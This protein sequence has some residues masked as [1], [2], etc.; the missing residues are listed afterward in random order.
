M[1]A[2]VVGL[3]S[4]GRRHAR[5]WASLG[6]GPLLAYR[7]TNTL[8]PQRQHEPEQQHD[9]R[10][11]P[12]QYRGQQHDPQGQKGPRP[13]QD[14]SGQPLG[15]EIDADEFHDLDQALAEQPDVVFVTNPT[16]LHLDAACRAI[17]AGAHVFVEKP[18]SDSLAGVSELLATARQAQRHVMVGYNLRFHPGLVRLRELVRQ[19]AVGKIVSA[20]AEVGEYLPD[21]HPWEDY[22]ASYSGRRDLGGGAVLTLSHDLDA[23]CWVLG[24]PSHVFG[25]AV[26][27]SSLEIDTEDVAEL[28]LRF[29]RGH[30][31]TAVAS[32]HMDY[33]RR[34]PQRSLEIVGEDGV[35]RWEYEANRL[36]RYLPRVRQWR[37]EE[38][39]PGFERNE[40]F[41]DELRHFVGCVRGEIE[42]PLID[43]EQAAAVLAIALAGLRS[44]NE[45]TMID[46]RAE[47]EPV[48]TWLTR[49][50]SP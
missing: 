10:A 27:A 30:S 25:M 23:L 11:Q 32:V 29:P 43:G 22:R 31:P 21:W 26:H 8:Q 3:G 41:L 44:S 19:N 14:T 46:L 34:P 9:R 49:L 40:M 4:I 42:R 5:N 39:H 48:S 12:P 45:G 13:L 47:G 2:L 20:R 38:A 35:L 24:A 15:T 16:S 1:R 6:L 33:L 17:Q 28:V 7:H 37:V 18:L 36:V 50:G